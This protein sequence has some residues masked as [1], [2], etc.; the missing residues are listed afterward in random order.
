MLESGNQRLP[1]PDMHKHRQN[2]R[3]CPES[4]ESS[5]TPRAQPRGSRPAHQ[6]LLD[7]GDESLVDDSHMGLGV[8]SF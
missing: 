5:Q 3:G 6:I 1:Q 4:Y 7:G 8:V 2:L